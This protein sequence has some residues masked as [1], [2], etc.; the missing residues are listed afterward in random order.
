[1][2]PAPLIFEEIEKKAELFPEHTALQ[3]MDG[4]QEVRYTFG[5]TLRMAKNLSQSL[6]DRGFVKGDKVV[7]WSPLN[8]HWTIAYLGVLYS[9]CVAA[10][11][12]VEYGSDE[13]SFILC[14]LET[15]LV[16]TTREKL[17]L[18]RSLMREHQLA[19]TVVSLDGD[20]EDGDA[21]RVEEL[22]QESN[23]PFS[24]PAISLEDDAIIFYTSGTTGK[25]KGVIIQ[26]QSIA[27]SVAGLMQYIHFIR[28]DRV[29]AIIPSHHVF[30]SLANVLMPLATGAGVTYLRTLNSVE[31]MKTLRLARIT[32]LPAVPQLFY[33]LHKKIF[34]EVGRKSFPVRVFFRVML[35]LCL[36]LRETTHLNLGRKVFSTVH[37]TFGGSLRLLISAASY[38]DPKIIR[39]F[40]SLG[41]TVQQGYALTETFGGGMFTP[42]RKNVIGSTGVPLPGLKVKLVDPDESGEGEIAINGPS[43]MR[44]YFNNPEATAQVLRDGWFY[45]GDLARVD[46][47]GNYYITGRKK[48]LI[49]LSSGKKVYPEEV[50]RHYMQCPYIKEMC[51][52][53]AADSSGYAQS[54]RLHAVIVPDF[55]YLKQLKIVNSREIIRADVEK[56]SVTLPRYKRILSY[57]IQTEP[58]PRTSTKKLKRWLVQ[59]QNGGGQGSASAN[60]AQRAPY[61]SVEGDDQLLQQETSG[62][63]LSVIRKESRAEGELHPDM[64]LELDLG[65][66]SLQRTELIVN[67][68]Q[69]LNIRL[70]SDAASQLLTVRDL[71]KAVESGSHQGR[72][73][74]GSHTPAARVTWKEILGSENSDEASREIAEKYVFKS[75]PVLT[76]IY[77]LLLKLVFL[78]SKILFRLKVRGI[79]NL[80][81]QGPYLICPNHQSYLDGILFTAVLPYSIFKQAFSVGYSP[82]FVGGGLKD[83]IAR[84][85]KV[86]PIDPDTN[87]VRAM[88]VSAI[89]LKAKK[90]L[91]IFPEGGVSCDGQLKSFKKGAPVLAQELG[92][93]VLPAAITGSFNVW[94]K[95]TRR[96]GIA[97]IEI[98]F[99]K[100][101]NCEAQ[102]LQASRS[103]DS[104]ALL[105]R[106]MESAVRSLI[107]LSPDTQVEPEKVMDLD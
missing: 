91:L 61:N 43:V 83:F 39:D 15:R 73:A 89:S 16:F 88:K 75:S 45:T 93:P 86:V 105:A 72:S 17:P 82:Y 101:L 12:D 7:F 71:L 107:S 53:G 77:F 56:L 57:D 50:E 59:E 63:V 23:A 54:E 85:G 11:L 97:P 69:A 32:V 41:F 68:E 9:G 29:L 40:Y 49:V 98:V 24:P 27:N 67:I 36:W 48:E 84:I 52:L 2:K 95:G 35:R 92:V 90:I 13:M 87:L 38:F 51:V 60:T 34:E 94:S 102:E 6:R 99:G 5:Q 81:P 62:R 8:P 66:D 44:G 26:H 103:D 30:A 25:P 31:L 10:P 21:V 96:I 58:L 100:P 37:Q 19:L 1:M 74:A 64:N 20:E 70:D 22:F 4:E 33:L 78:L 42:F 14:E 80:P 76:F 3:M 47:D 106:K 104:Y 79:E 18:L 55:D 65:F 28:G 46:D